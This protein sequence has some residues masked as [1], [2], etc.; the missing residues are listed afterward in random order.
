MCNH[1]RLSSHFIF[2]LEFFPY[3]MGLSKIKD[4]LFSSEFLL[5]FHAPPGKI[6]NIVS[7]VRFYGLPPGLWIS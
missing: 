1:S 7:V 2:S 3:P 6:L 5:S 4:D